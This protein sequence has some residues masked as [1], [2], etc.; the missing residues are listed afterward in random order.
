MPTPFTLAAPDSQ[1]RI[2]GRDVDA[3]PRGSLLR[4]SHSQNFADD[5]YEGVR[6]LRRPTVVTKLPGTCVGSHVDKIALSQLEHMYLPGEKLVYPSSDPCDPPVPSRPPAPDSA[7]N[8]RRFPPIEPSELGSLDVS[9]SLLVE[10]EP[11][12]NWE[13]WE[14]RCNAVQRSAVWSS[15]ENRKKSP[16][17][18]VDKTTRHCC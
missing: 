1:I 4:D 9:V 15:A 14:V 17:D 13:D 11:A 7:L 18:V 2:P 10:Y 8:D 3:D 5:T 6:L 12:R 16:N